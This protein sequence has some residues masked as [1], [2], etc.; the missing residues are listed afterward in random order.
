MKIALYQMNAIVGDLVGNTN[1]LIHQ[2]NIAKQN[3][4]NLFIAT[5]LAICGYPP[6]DLLLR[7]DFYAQC[8]NQLNRLTEVY[9]INLLIGCPTRFDNNNYNSLYLISNGKVKNRYDKIKLPNFGVFDE[10]RY[11]SSGNLSSLFYINDIP[12]IIAICEDVW[13]GDTIRESLYNDAKLI[14]VVNASPFCIGKHND[15]L[16]VTRKRV[17]ET[18]LPLIYLNQIGGQ[19]ELVFDGASFVLDNKGS[20]IYQASAFCEE[21]FYLDFINSEL[22]SHQKNY[23]YPSSIE[24]IYQSLVLS[25]KDYVNKNNFNGIVLGLSGGIDSA[26]TMAIAVDALGKD[27]VVAV[28]MPTEYTSEISLIDSREIVKNLDVKY[29]EIEIDGLFTNF[30]QVLSPLFTN[31]PT[32]TTE[33]NLQARIRGVTLMAIS[34]KF[35][36]LV[37]TTGNKSEMTTGY[38][39]LYGDMAGG[40]A[41]LKDVSKTLVYQLAKFKNMQNHIIPDR[42][43][44]RAPSA[45]LRPNQCDQDSLPPYDELDEIMQQLVEGNI[46]TKA[47]ILNGYD[48]D[49]VHQI[50]QLLQRNEYKRRQ[51]AIGPK[52]TSTGYG[53]DWRYPI[54]NKFKI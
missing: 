7:S 37:V 39:T 54:T 28:M 31:L 35:G 9:D 3:G 15:R 26:L 33:E 51:A 17:K 47:L 12:C 49:K 2:I 41:L 11:F 22:S 34:N 6:E 43:I 8:A 24:A 1:K 19:D 4:A 10:G 38:A 21:L 36:Y 40:F 45:E 16:N 50:S 20:F 46:S 18:N 44:D 30:N 5:E 42:I 13:H 29:H 27:N 32:D 53:R 23:I 48:E 52:I 25:I 14:I